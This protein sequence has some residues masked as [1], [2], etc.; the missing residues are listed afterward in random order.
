MPRHLHHSTRLGALGLRE[1]IAIG[2]GGM[3]GGGIFSIL[4]LGAQIAGTGVVYALA[5]GGA[6]ATFAAYSYVRL[7]ATFPTDGASYTYVSR[8]FEE[9]PTY[10][11]VTG[12]TVILGYMGTLSLY[13]YTF[14]AYAG[15]LIGLGGNTAARLVL[16]SSI[17]LLLMAVNLGGARLT[18]TAED[19]VVYTKIAILTGFGIT[20]LVVSRDTLITPTLDKGVGSILV[21]GALIFV[22]YEGF[23]LIANAVEETD[24]P[25]RNV[26]RGMYSSIAIVTLI[27]V[28]LAYVAISALSVEELVAA[29]EYALAAAAQPVL[30]EVGTI[31][32]GLAAMLATSSAVNSTLFGASR[33]MAE[34]GSDRVMPRGFATRTGHGVPKNALITMTA[35]GLAL[36][37]AGSL[38]V[39]ASFSSLT[40]L[41][42]SLVVSVAN[43]Q[44]KERT[45]ARTWIVVTGIVLMA[46]TI[47]LLIWYLATNQPRDLAF[48]AVFYGA[49]LTAQQL[50]AR[51]QRYREHPDG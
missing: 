41:V 48:V 22:A 31:L 17:L 29:K 8:A 9:H 6:V 45:G 24:D 15:D 13:A 7:S 12:W 40:F 30:G 27:Y 26:P 16:S 46:A 20:G 38:E 42:V 44:L 39:I 32:V 4:G 43:L 3:I 33:M 10:G 34:M 37:L 11:A 25:I 2:V 23:Q 18:G 28:G 51:R 47:T 5:I 50:F 49:A 14:G 1:L 35:V 19:F 21:A 36:S